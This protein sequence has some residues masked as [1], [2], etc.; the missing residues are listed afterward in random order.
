MLTLKSTKYYNSLDFSEN[1]IKDKEDIN[2]LNEKIQLEFSLQNVKGECTYHIRAHLLNIKES[3]YISEKRKPTPN[4]NIIFD[5]FYICDYFFE[6]E[7]KIQITIYRNNSKISL[8]TTLG[9]IV[10]SRFCTFA[11]KYDENEV[12]MIKAAK[13]G[14]GD[15]SLDI[16]FSLK[17]NGQNS[18]YFRNNNNKLI[19]EISCKGH[20]I[21]SS[22]SINNYGDFQN[23]KIPICLLNPFFT[24]SLY[25]SYNQL[26]GN[27][28][29]NVNEI[30]P[31]NNNIIL[32]IPI[33]NN[34]YLFLYESL[35]IIENYTFLDFI[36]SGVRI[37]LSIG[38]DFTG[39]N[40]HPLDEGTLHSLKGQMPSDYERAIRACGNI[41]AYYDY[42]QLFP[43][44][45][46]GAI[47]NSSP[48]KE[49]SMC[50]NLNFQEN[51][52][53]YTVENI[54]KCYHDCIS[55]DK[56]TFAGP[57]K[58]A[59][60]INTIISKIQNNK[61]EYHILMILTDGVIDDLQETIDALVEGSFLPLSVIII[62]IGNADFKK[63]E[64]LDGDD[65]PL[66]SSK[67]VKRM[68]DLVQF[69]PFNRYENDEHKLSMEVLE[70]IPRQI[71]DYYTINNL[72]PNK[73]KESLSKNNINGPQ[74]LYP[75][76]DLENAEFNWDNVPMAESIMLPNGYNDLIK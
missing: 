48:I 4:N 27:L 38:I 39:S 71:V 50:F 9:C 22:E 66:V 42:D 35:N 15:K 30:K 37:G 17:L 55:Q 70:E 13:I 52:D 8:E 14:K 59:P 20:K 24:I 68:R 74:D 51:P 21:Y 7:Q 31:N 73:I 72:D 34:N 18:D 58:F 65:V 62:G 44:F 25:N 28:N 69:V 76:F 54:I 11:R 19:Y 3:G 40:G 29:K 53:I 23:V 49:A 41:V 60:L 12:L 43:V 2:S 46:F 67:G 56:L 10:G 6:K 63:M 16:K 75:H 64:V 47:I 61:L 57:T 5:K 32:K 45:G 26:I 36:T 33:S 1:K